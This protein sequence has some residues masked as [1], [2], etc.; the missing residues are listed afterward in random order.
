MI[1]FKK[2]ENT[3]ILPE[4]CSREMPKKED[5]LY[6]FEQLCKKNVEEYMIFKKN[7]FK[8]QNL[9]LIKD[10]FNKFENYI[11]DENTNKDNKEVISIVFNNIKNSVKMLEYLEMIPNENKNKAF[12]MSFISSR[13]FS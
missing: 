2:N 5:V 8:N 6:F 3:S 7:S 11:K 12:I 1:D 13:L 4:N 10:F 9:E